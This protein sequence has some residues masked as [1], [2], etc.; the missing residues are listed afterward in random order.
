MSEVAAPKAIKEQ[1]LIWHDYT[2]NKHYFIDASKG[3]QDR[4][5]PH[6]NVVRPFDPNLTGK[7]DYDGRKKL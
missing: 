7:Y 5:D 6:G 3:T 4:S 2:S 1:S